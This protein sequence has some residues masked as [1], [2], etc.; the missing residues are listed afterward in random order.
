VHLTTTCCIAGGGPAGV[1]L[2]FLLARLGV[3]VIVLEKHADFFRDFRGDTIHPSTLAVL[4]ELGLVDE[5]LKLPHQEI[6]GASVSINGA[7]M[8]L[9]DLDAIHPKWNFVAMVPQWDF[10]DFLAD[11]GKE[12]P[13]FRLIMQAEV[14]DL[15]YDA[16]RVVGVRARTPDGE[17]AI[18]AR[19]TVGCDGR[20]STVRQ[21]ARLPVQNFGVPIDVLW[22]RIPKG[23][24]TAS[25]ALGYFGDGD[26]LVL[27]ERGDYYQAAF[28]IPKGSFDAIK[29]AG[30]PAFLDRILKLAPFLASTVGEIR[31]WSEVKL[32]TVRIDRLKTWH[33][34]GLLCIG[35]AAHAM[36]PVGGVGINLAIQ[37]AVATA[38]IIGLKLLSG[39]LVERDL[40]AVQ[41]RRMWPTRVIQRMQRFVHGNILNPRM[42]A[43]NRGFR[44]LRFLVRFSVFR[45][46]VAR[47]IGFGPRPEHIATRPSEV[48]PGR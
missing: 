4:E 3:D 27:F 34:A 1:L 29:G 14:F 11:R 25:P 44:V 15:I 39:T 36:S 28:L 45:R 13:G 10:L 24:T 6:H 5:F 2:G 48:G 22:L 38:N 46:L 37:D 33:T 18:Q 40:A 35:D 26:F 21:I 47:F 19:L 43:R 32:L 8:K 17:L 9:A 23:N 20:H 12:L 31:D 16:E 30:L 7:V 41:R 42:S